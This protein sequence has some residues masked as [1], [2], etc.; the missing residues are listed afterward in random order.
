MPSNSTFITGNC[1]LVFRG[2]R[3][4]VASSPWGSIV[5]PIVVVVGM[6]VV[7]V[8]S[9]GS[10]WCTVEIVVVVISS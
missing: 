10:W 1:R 7:V 2:N 5:V 4:G 3:Y 6:V 8:D 9:L